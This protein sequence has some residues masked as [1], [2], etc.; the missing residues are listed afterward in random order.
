[1]ARHL[2]IR[3]QVSLA[4][5]TTLG[6]GGPARFFAGC[7]SD[8]DI[9]EGIHLARDLG[10][11]LLILGGGSNVVIADEGFDGLVLKVETRG[12]LRESTEGGMRLT[13]AAGER[14]DD[15][16]CSCIEQGLAGVECL[17]GIPGSVGATP[18]QN[19]GAYGQEVSQTIAEVTVLDVKTG[20]DVVFRNADCRFAYRQSRFKHADADRYVVT[21]VTFLL[22]AEGR[23]VI[24]YP[25]LEKSIAAAVDLAAL[26]SGAPVLRAVREAVLGLRRRKSMVIDPD[27]PNTRSVGSFFTNP[28][29]PAEAAEKL[30]AAYAGLPTFASGDGVKIP[31]AWLV[32][33]AGFA[34][35]YMSAGAA[36]SENHT[37]ALVNRG[38]TS[39][40]LLSLAQ[41]ITDA[42][43]EKFGIRLE[44]EPVVV[45]ATAAGN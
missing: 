41:R 24:R 8:A 1:M 10:L 28:V 19:V 42:V 33:Q 9:L 14:W 6:L 2:R 4:P 13:V 22:Q 30:R 18:I 12:T 15:F 3:E 39:A 44:K 45:Q 7:R 5:Y 36:V 32:E 17:S 38:T 11:R 29:V 40:A 25:E 37:L 34:R 21:A 31:A 43:E 27:D 16:V 26:E 35:G 23:P 20:D